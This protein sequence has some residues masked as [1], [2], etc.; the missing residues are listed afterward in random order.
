TTA[1]CVGDCD[2]SGMVTIS[3]LVTGVN[4]ALGSA[5]VSAC[6]SFDCQ[7]NGT[8]PINCLIQGGNNALEGCPATPVVTT[9]P[10]GALGVRR[11]SLNPDHSQFIAVLSEGGNFPTSGL[12]GFLELSA[13]PLTNGL[14]FV[15]ITDASDYLSV[16]VPA[17][18]TAICLKVLKDQLPIHNAGLLSCSGGLPLGIQVTQDHNIGV[19]GACSG[20]DN[21]GQSCSGDT[22]CPAG[23]CTTGEKCADMH[24]TV[25]GPNRPHPGVCNGPIDG[26]QDTVVSPPGTLV[27]APDPNG[28]IKGL[29]VELTQETSTPCGDEGATGMSL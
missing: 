20:G 5:P 16:D 19:L 23:P 1:A 13:G 17:G 22:D 4:I 14:A 3:E 6:P 25:E 11:F 8:V 29:P 18:G 21:E 15:D 27:I 26:V 10:G 24:G 2:G 28:I 9:T 12:Q 7:H